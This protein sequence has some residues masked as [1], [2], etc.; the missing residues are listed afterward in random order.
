MGGGW[1]GGINKALAAADIDM[2]LFVWGT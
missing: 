1:G 2:A